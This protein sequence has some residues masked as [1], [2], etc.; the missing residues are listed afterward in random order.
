MFGTARHYHYNSSTRPVGLWIR[1][2]LAHK[3]QHLFVS[4]GLK[5]LFAFC[6][7]HVQ[8]EEQVVLRGCHRGCLF[9]FSA[10]GPEM[11]PF[12]VALIEN[13]PPG[14]TGKW[15]KM[16]P[17]DTSPGPRA[18][19]ISDIH[20]HQQFISTVKRGS[21][22]YWLITETLASNRLGVCILADSD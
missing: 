15:S 10:L 1:F 16:V 4:R 8:K 19:F 7:R 5:D 9:S 20:G 13:S 2:A 11:S 22:G 12:P 14:A 6:F 3:G 17:P 18:Q 21:I